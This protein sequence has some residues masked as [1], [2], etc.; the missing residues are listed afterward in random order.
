MWAV[1]VFN[2][3]LGNSINSLGIRP[4]QMMGLLGII[5]S[6]F[7]HG[8]LLHLI[9][10][11]I[12]FAVMGAV[13]AFFYKQDFIDVLI[14]VTLLTGFCTWVLGTS[15]SNHI[16]ASGVV[17]GLAGFIMGAGFFTKKF[18]PMSIAIVVVVYYGLPLLTG[19]IPTRA[20]I[21]YLGHWMGLLAGIGMA[22]LFKITRD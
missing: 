11:T 10:N 17:F 5:S 16:G 6:P 18:V 2:L 4:R 14:G 19:L 21:S 8:S 13:L 3:L 22:Y 1:Y 7:L 15:N 12:P 9:G 20:G